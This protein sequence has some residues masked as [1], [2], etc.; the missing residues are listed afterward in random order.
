MA[1]VVGLAACRAQPAALAEPIASALVVRNASVFDIN[2]FAL[3]DDGGRKWLVTVPAN[4]LRSLPV[5]P[6]TLRSRSTLVVQ[7]QAVGAVSTWTSSPVKITANVFAVLDLA[8]TS[9]GDCSQSLL[10]S[11]TANE[12]SAALR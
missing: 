3:L 7:T 9:T 1:L 4:S 2:V 6:T 10:S 12:L 5:L 8:T 11:I